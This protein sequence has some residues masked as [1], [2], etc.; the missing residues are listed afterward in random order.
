[1]TD[2]ELRALIRAELAPIRADV[3]SIRAEMTSVRALVEGIPLTNRALVVLQ[4]E[5]R[6]LKAAFNDFARTNVTAGE[7]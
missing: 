4:Q 7:I 3:T 1:M 6:G 2:E 5:V